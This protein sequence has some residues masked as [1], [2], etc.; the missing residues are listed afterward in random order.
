MNRRDF[1][2]RLT[3]SVPVAASVPPPAMVNR[4]RHQMPVQSIR[5][6]STP[7]DLQTWR[8]TL[9]DN[10]LD[11][12]PTEITLSEIQHFPSH[13]TPR[14]IACIGNP[15]GGTMIGTASWRG[16]RARDVLGNKIPFGA[17]YAKLTG[18]DGYQTALPI[19]MLLHSETLLVYEMDGQPLPR[20]HGYPL[21]LVVAGTYGQKMV[22]A[23][24]SIEWIDHTFKGYWESRGWS[25]D[26]IVQTHAIIDPLQGI[27]PQGQSIRIQGIAF[28][29]DRAIT[30][31]DIRFD[32]GAWIPTTLNQPETPLAW[33]PWFLDWTPETSGTIQIEARATDNQGF[34]QHQPSDGTPNEAFP[35]GIA[36]IHQIMVTIV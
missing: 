30:Q 8:L 35:N 13:I 28:A 4:S 11:T 33:T 6:A 2:L 12:P 36:S 14:T 24:T 15:L 23:L 1:L 17:T 18:H 3:G 19:A 27:F 9:K 5:V 26:S 20:E 29:G 21:R 25:D 34:T 22:K 16:V 31:V 7:V 10:N 32:G